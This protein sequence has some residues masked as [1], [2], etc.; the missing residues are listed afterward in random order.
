[1]TTPASRAAS[2]RV[3]LGTRRARAQLVA[4]LLR[5][6]EW[7][8]A[9]GLL[10]HVV[11]RRAFE[12]AY[13]TYK[14]LI[15]AGP[16]SQL[17]PVVAPGSTV[18]DVGANIGFFTLRFG[19][20]V[21]PAGRVVAIEPEERNVAS[22]RRRV[23]RARLHDVIDCVQAA[24]A[25]LPGEVRIAVNHNHPGDHHLAD[26]GEPIRAVT[27]DELTEGDPRTVAL[28]KVD[29]QGA[30]ALVLEG[31]ARVIATHRPAIFIEVDDPSLKRLG[32][33]ASE[34]IRELDDLGYRGHMLT[35]RGIGT[36]ETPEALLAR[37]TS[38]YIDVLF[39]PAISSAG[40]PEAG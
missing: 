7:A 20:W 38:A 33:S 23:R 19:R 1:M 15:E 14:L 2:E 28:V 6:Y 26:T 17:K 40:T 39:L 35:R 3:V 24:A 36:P 16:V 29:V 9:R 32:S 34:L 22:L 4:S 21:G 30:E 13:L 8:L 18:I 25:A 10:D 31:A 11:A 5:L 27:I 12:S 37:S